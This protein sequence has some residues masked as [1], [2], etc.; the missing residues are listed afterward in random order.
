M[1]QRYNSNSTKSTIQQE[2]N[3][4]VRINNVTIN[5]CMYYEEKNDHQRRRNYSHFQNVVRIDR[6]HL[7]DDYRIHAKSLETSESSMK[8]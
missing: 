5:Q 3:A 6:I 8:M 1:S 2:N 4:N 7:D